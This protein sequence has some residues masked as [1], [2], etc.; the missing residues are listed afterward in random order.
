[1]SH[2]LFTARD[3]EP[4]MGDLGARPTLGFTRAL[5]TSPTDAEPSAPAARIIHAKALQVHQPTWL[6]RLGVRRAPGYHKCGSQQALDWVRAFRLRAWT[7]TGWKTHRYETGLACPD[8]DTLLWF[9]LNDLHTSAVILEVRRSGI[10]D[11]WTP[12]NLAAEAFVLDGDPVPLAPRNESRLDHEV[13]SLSSLPDGLKAHVQD[14]AVRFRSQQLD[15][16]FSLGRA[17]FSHLCLDGRSAGALDAN[18]LHREP[19]TF[20][21]GLQ[22]HPV[23]QSPVA[24]P[25]LRYD[26]EGTTR[27][28]DN[29]VQY[30]V[31]LGQTGL[32]YRLEWT[33]RPDRLTLHAERESSEALR[34]WESSAWLL[35]VRS[36][37]SPAHVLA[38]LQKTGETGWVDPPAWLHAPSYG[39]FRIRPSN[40]N[41]ALRTNVY[42]AQDL[43]T[44]EFK[45]GE[46]PQPEGDYLLPAGH[47]ETTLDWIVDAPA[48]PL[49]DAAP[50]SV[51]K[52]VKRCGLTALT[53]RPDTSTLSNN[54]ASIHC[55]HSME[56]WAATATQLGEVLPETDA[57]YFLR[58]SLERWLDGGPGYASGPLLKKDED[59]HPAEDEYLMTG[60]SGLLGLA[61][62]LHHRGTP[63]WV[64]RYRAPIQHRLERMRARDLDDDGLIESPHRTGV[65]GTG[66]WSTC[67]L[68]VVSFGWKDAFANALLYPALTLLADTLPE[69]GAPAL[70]EGLDAW[71]RQ[72][73]KN[74]PPTF[75]NP[76]TGWVAGWRCKEG[77]LHDYAFLPVNGAAV[78]GGL[79]DDET[80]RSATERLWA[81]AERV[82]LP[83]LLLGLPCSLRPIPDRDLAGIMQGYPQGY[84]QNGG[85]THS[86]AHLFVEALYAVGMTETGDRVL[87]RLCKGLADGRTVGGSK[88]GVDWRYWDDRPS[89][90]EGLLTEQFGLVGTALRRYGTASPLSLRSD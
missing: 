68:D 14:G 4:P 1:M 72:L 57:A 82:G 61:R 56:H 53:Y 69:L 73:R 11:W 5:W 90:Y 87:E 6:R 74:Y 27:V 19:G 80:A 48:P 25:S 34:A 55:P 41:A 26:V 59:L 67:W 13:A 83:D 54:G 76:E 63:D 9:D 77:A 85:R 32:R 70:A 65:S 39:S 44:T 31:T 3:H 8:P 50:S 71:A 22:L 33:V 30:A 62:F 64:Q 79:L 49:Q 28:V 84:Y 78:C 75:F 60:T 81:E 89:G 20:H 12:W 40:E 51:K 38:R 7:G 10:D 52:A 2:N 36:T 47:F 37:V 35:G 88:S 43:L 18:L 42:R 45:L 46:E 66:Q 16:G 17:G 15:V 29:R 86:Q 24:A 58:T 23:G 21:Q